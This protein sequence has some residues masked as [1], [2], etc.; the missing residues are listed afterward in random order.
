MVFSMSEDLTD[1][2]ESEDEPFLGS[3]FLAGYVLGL[4]SA[5]SLG[6]G[7]KELMKKMKTENSNKPGFTLGKIAGTSHI[8]VLYTLGFGSTLYAIWDINNLGN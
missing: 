1:R 8:G 3:G 6:F 4:Y 7:C 2:F 5:M